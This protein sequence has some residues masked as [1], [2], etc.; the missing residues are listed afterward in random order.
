MSMIESIG[1]DIKTAMKARD[2]VRLE[3][4]RSIKK[5]LFD[6]TVSVR[7]TGQT[8]LTPEQEIEAL[9]QIAKQRRDAI[10]QYNNVGRPDAAAQEALELTII[11]EFLPTQASDA[12]IAAAVA[13]VA[14]EVGA[15][16]AKDMGKVMSAVM[17]QLKGQ[18]DGKKVQAAVKAHLGG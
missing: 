12:A 14:T 7:P 1:E 8:D 9:C 16:T 15:K 4:L 18:A 11:E 17:Q 13:A 2:K 5:V 3:T 6:K 10:E